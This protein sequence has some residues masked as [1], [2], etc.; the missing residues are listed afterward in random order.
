MRK[1]SIGRKTQQCHFAR[2]GRAPGAMCSR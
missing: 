1:H 2:S